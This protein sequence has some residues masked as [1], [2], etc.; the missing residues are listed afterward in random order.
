MKVTKVIFR[1]GRKRKPTS[2]LLPLGSCAT[3]AS[4]V[5]QVIF[6][7]ESEFENEG[8]WYFSEH[9]SIEWEMHSTIS[10]STSSLGDFLD[11]EEFVSRM[12][13]YLLAHRIIM[14]EGQ[15]LLFCS[16]S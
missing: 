12:F 7:D 5:V 2:A 14:K 15:I 4:P 6:V 13:Q 1:S 3:M 8:N 10:Q 9:K 16:Y 11:S